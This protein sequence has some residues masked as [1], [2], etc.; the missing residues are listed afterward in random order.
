MSNKWLQKI[1]NKQLERFKPEQRQLV[2]IEHPV[3]LSKQVEKQMIMATAEEM[4]M[5]RKE[6]PNLTVRL[7]EIEDKKQWKLSSNLFDGKTA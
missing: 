2:I 6:Y 5:Y 7:A 4:D 1:K 3:G